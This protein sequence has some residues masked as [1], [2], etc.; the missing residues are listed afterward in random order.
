MGFSLMNDEPSF[1]DGKSSVFDSFYKGY[2]NEPLPDPSLEAVD[3]VAFLGKYASDDLKDARST[4]PDDV[5][6]LFRQVVP[7]AFSDANVNA[8]ADKYAQRQ[9]ST[10][11]FQED[12]DNLIDKVSNKI[13]IASNWLEKH[14]KL[15]ELVAGTIGGA[16]MAEEKRKAA[17]AAQQGR[18]NEQNNAARIAQ[19]QNA[20]FSASISGL[21]PRKKGLINQPPLKRLGG[22]NVFDKSGKVA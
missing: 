16:Y 22:S 4:A 11:L 8:R 13:D 15:T 3:P 17:E 20:A 9:G 2:E 12:Q 21:A 18:L 14:K 6:E 10:P 1:D 7:E 5:Q 19:E